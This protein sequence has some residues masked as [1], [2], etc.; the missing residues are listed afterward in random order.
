MVPVSIQVAPGPVLGSLI[1]N[2]FRFARLA[3][4]M[5]GGLALGACA[6]PRDQAYPEEDTPVTL[7]QYKGNVLEFRAEPGLDVPQYAERIADGAEG[8]PEHQLYVS[9]SITNRG[10]GPARLNHGACAVRIR[11]YRSP[12]R[13]G[14]PAWTSEQY[15]PDWCT[16]IL[17]H[18]EL[19]PGETAVAKGL[20][21][22]ISTI[23][24]HRKNPRS[25]PPTPRPDPPPRGRYYLSARAE[26]YNDS[27]PV[28]LFP[29][30]GPPPVRPPHI[31]TIHVPA[32]SVYLSRAW[33]SK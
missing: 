7:V 5:A 6:E 1:R 29:R 27:L 17:H 24:V 13:T 11:A 4:C 12:A 33:S 14:P 3:R 30:E 9:V 18:R 23:D 22:V 31:D 19:A 20:Q 16:D 25:R 26:L 21:D 2:A 10:P 32:G 15:R 8:G 28:P